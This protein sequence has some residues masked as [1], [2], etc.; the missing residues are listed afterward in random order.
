MR[1]Y[2]KLKLLGLGSNAKLR[3]FYI[4]QFIK[5]TPIQKDLLIGIL[6]GDNSAWPNH[7]EKV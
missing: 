7:Y 2:N 6:L 5:L 4:N 3:T 1:K